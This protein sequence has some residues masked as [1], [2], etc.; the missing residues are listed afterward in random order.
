[1]GLFWAFRI[2]K[3]LEIMDL[4]HNHFTLRFLQI[5]QQEKNK[6]SLKK[7][8]GLTHKLKAKTHAE[9]V[10]KNSKTT[11]P[12]NEIYL[13]VPKKCTVTKEPGSLSVQFC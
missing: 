12:R 7:K 10:Y 2:Q 5:Y 4:L 11:K 3:M 6:Q 13:I 1:M 9:K 8:K